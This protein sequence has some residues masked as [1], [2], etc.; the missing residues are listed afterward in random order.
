MAPNRHRLLLCPEQPDAS[1]AIANHCLP[2]RVDDAHA[3][4]VSGRRCFV[5]RWEGW[6]RVG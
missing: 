4:L 3:G 2:C 6:V 1:P 5:R